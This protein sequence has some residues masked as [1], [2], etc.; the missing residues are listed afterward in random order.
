MKG[1]ILDFTVQ[2]NSGIISGDDN[3]RYTCH[4]TDWMEQDPPRRGMAVDF[5]TVGDQATQIY[6]ALGA[7]PASAYGSRA[8]GTGAGSSPN[9]SVGGKDSNA[10]QTGAMC[11]APELHEATGLPR[12]PSILAWYWGG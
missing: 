7:R 2:T 9:Y 3:Q 10:P 5:A 12:T 8:A 11:N 4:G 1:H 6:A